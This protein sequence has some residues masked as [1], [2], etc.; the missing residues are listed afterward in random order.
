MNKKICIAIAF[1]FL[2]FISFAQEDETPISPIAPT[3]GIIFNIGNILEG[4]ESYQGGVG[5]KYDREQIHWRFLLDLY[6]DYGSNLFSSSIGASREY[7]LTADIISPYFGYNISTGFTYNKNESYDQKEFTIPVNLSAL[8][9]CTWQLTD[10]LSVFAEYSLG[11]EYIFSSIIS[12]YL[13]DEIES[14]IIINTGLG[15]SGKIGII[16]YFKDMEHIER[17]DKEK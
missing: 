7:P 17:K 11:I 10:F 3:Y 9:G 1:L 5:L 12:P 6:Y 14:N 15:N 2:A 13:E 8:F 4:V 16:I